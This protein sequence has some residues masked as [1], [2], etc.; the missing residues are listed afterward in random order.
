MRK[1]TDNFTD[2]YGNAIYGAN[3]YVYNTGT[4]TKA[5]LY[6]DN[7]VTTIS[8]PLTTDSE[9]EYSF[10]VANGAY[11]IKHVKS[12]YD[13]LVVDKVQIFDFSEVITALQANYWD[14]AQGSTP[15]ATAA[16]EYWLDTDDGY[17]YKSTAAGTENWVFQFAIPIFNLSGN[18]DFSNGSMIRNKTF[19]NQTPDPFYSLDGVDDK[20]SFIAYTLDFNAGAFFMVRFRKVSASGTA[21]GIFGNS[22]HSGYDNLIANATGG[23]LGETA[24]NTDIYLS[25]TTQAH[26]ND[27]HK[28]VVTGSGK[29]VYSYLDGKLIDTRVVT[30]GNVTFDQL[31]AIGSGFGNIAYAGHAF[32]NRALTEAEAIAHSSNPQMAF[33]GKDEFGSLVAKNLSSCINSTMTVFSGASATGFHAESDGSTTHRC[34]SADE[35][36]TKKGHTIRVTGTGAFTVGTSVSVFIKTTFGGTLLSSTTGAFQAGENVIE[37]FCTVDGTGVIDF[38]SFS[39]AVNFDISNLAVIDLGVTRVYKGK[40]FQEDFAFDSSGNNSTL[41]P[42]GGA[43]LCNKSRVQTPKK[44]TFDATLTCG[45]SGTIT[46]NSSFNALNWRREGA[47]FEVWGQIKVT[48]V[49]SPVGSLILGGFPYNFTDTAETSENIAGSVTTQTLASAATAGVGFA[50]KVGTKTIEICDGFNG[51]GAIGSDF[52]AHIQANTLITVFI[53]AYTLDAM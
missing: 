6:Q 34:G 37:F 11:D 35:I 47:M 16:D 20:L 3:V 42:S 48:S 19:M 28:I 27:W 40:D 30:D 12:G 2:E 31:G 43:T 38:T 53:R 17:V 29:T 36:V 9:G 33:E 15:S 44:G 1:Y 18:V 14:F 24:T 32:G 46:L 22:A 25:T 39:T 41:T 45:T 13:T 10:K 4:E 8:N 23:Y 7:E 5:T 52:A 26:D 50:A 51:T 21:A 49:S